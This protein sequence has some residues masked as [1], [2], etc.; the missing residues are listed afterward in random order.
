MIGFIDDELRQWA[1]WSIL[2]KDGGLGYPHQVNFARLGGGACSRYEP[3]VDENAM[4]MERCVLCLPH[5]LWCV[6]DYW[7]RNPSANITSCSLHCKCHRETVYSRLNRAHI[8]IMGWLNDLESGVALPIP[9]KPKK[10]AGLRRNRLT[11]VPTV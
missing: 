5:D 3:I 8:K 7:Y 2:R 10:D 1:A 6:V 4:K 11:S 9:R